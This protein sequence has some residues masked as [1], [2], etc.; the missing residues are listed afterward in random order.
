MRE[1]ELPDSEEIF[2]AGHSRWSENWTLSWLL[3][4]NSTPVKSWAGMEVAVDAI[5]TNQSEMSEQNVLR[6]ISSSCQCQLWASQ[7]ACSKAN[8]VFKTAEMWGVRGFGATS[9]HGGVEN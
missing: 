9:P 8:F 4:I 3:L 7:E 1:I 2:T 5:N 6:N